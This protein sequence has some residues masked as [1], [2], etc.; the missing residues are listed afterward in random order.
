[1]EDVLRVAQYISVIGG[2]I[3]VVWKAVSFMNKIEL[4]IKEINSK[5]D[6]D[7]KRIEDLQT[8]TKHICTMMVRIAD[9]MITGNHVEKMKETRDEILSYMSEV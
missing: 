9:H 7:N 6:N 2:A 4:E 3:V 1:M 8:S 5:L